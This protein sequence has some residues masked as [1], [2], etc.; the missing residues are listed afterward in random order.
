[1]QASRQTALDFG[2]AA[3][4]DLL[5][6]RH[7][8]PIFAAIKVATFSEQRLEHDA[9]PWALEVIADYGR[10]SYLTLHGFAP[11]KYRRTVSNVDRLTGLAVDLDYYKRPDLRHLSPDEL[12]TRI[13]RDI[14]ALPMPTA[15]E[16]SGRGA[17]LLWTFTYPLHAERFRAEWQYVQR[18]L[19]G[20]LKPYGADLGCTDAARYTRLVGSINSQSGRMAGM[21]L[22]GDTVAFETMRRAVDAIGCSRLQACPAAPSTEPWQERKRR[23]QFTA[24]KHSSLNSYRLHADR[25]ADLAKLVELRGGTL[26]DHRRR[27]L[28][29]LATSL[30]W[31]CGDEQTV[32]NELAAFRDMHFADPHNYGAGIVS[33]VIQRLR[34]KGIVAGRIH[35]GRPAPHQF[36]MSN[37]YVI[38]ALEISPEEQRE[39][40]TIISKAESR[41]RLEERR[42]A[43][44]MVPREVLT[45]R[46]ETYR[47]QV[48]ELRA[49]GVTETV[50]ADRLGI[51]QPYVSLLQA[52]KR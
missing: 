36:R 2:P 43:A 33:G 16:D 26:T 24:H 6:G 3:Q 41:R 49:R 52:G 32:R 14:P 18:E 29:V 5:H 25:L 15:I 22:T 13:L 19:A 8:H 45:A 30:C 7:D 23:R 34:E 28:F 27:M 9:A 37:R 4:F 20:L 1:M 44:G 40:A 42:R 46:K 39:L 10:D 35:N 50:I 21:R 51:S 48:H 38:G 11:D 47:Q 12:L 17:W 31:Y